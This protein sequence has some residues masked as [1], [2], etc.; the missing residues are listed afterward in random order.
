MHDESMELTVATAIDL[1]LRAW[2]SIT[3][4]EVLGAWEK[5]IPLR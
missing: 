4:E 2:D 1:L 5:L 3:Q